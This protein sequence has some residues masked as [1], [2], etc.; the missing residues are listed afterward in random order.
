MTVR[1]KDKHLAITLV[2]PKVIFVFTGLPY[3]IMLSNVNLCRPCLF[4]EFLTALLSLLSEQVF[5][6]EQ[7][8]SQFCSVY[9]KDS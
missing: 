4:K 8:F 3:P 7:F 5:T 2:I 1:E 9:F 6:F